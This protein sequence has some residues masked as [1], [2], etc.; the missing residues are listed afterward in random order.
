MLILD[1][2]CI[3]NSTTIS[4]IKSCII[5]KMDFLWELKRFSRKQNSKIFLWKN[6]V[7]YVS[8]TR[9][10]KPFQILDEVISWRLQHVFA[11]FIQ[12]VCRFDHS[13]GVVSRKLFTSCKIYVIWDDQ[14]CVCMKNIYFF[15]RLY[16][17]DF[18]CST[19]CA[20]DAIYVLT[21]LDESSCIALRPQR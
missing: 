7:K 18:D 12:E 15:Y 5:T 1:F 17:F 9:V 3:L 21:V 10:W 11:S 6:Y 13:Y 4:Y 14:Y 8:T 20:G 2:V 16:N 19:Y